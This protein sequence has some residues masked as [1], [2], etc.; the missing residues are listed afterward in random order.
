[1]QTALQKHTLNQG[2]ALLLLLLKPCKQ[3]HLQSITARGDHTGPP[4][5]APGWACLGTAPAL[6]NLPGA[7]RVTRHCGTGLYC[8][9]TGN[10]HLMDPIA[11]SL[12]LG[13]P[14][15]QSR[16]PVEVQP[17]HLAPCTRSETLGSPDKSRQLFPCGR[18][19][20]EGTGQPGCAGS[21]KHVSA[22]LC[23][24]RGVLT[25]PGQACP[26]VVASTR[27]GLLQL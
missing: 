7:C 14:L 23:R 26:W 1:M 6:R 12:P 27:L 21:P 18:E 9:R 8:A 13:S 19:G 11:R 15:G 4:R 17:R 2:C 16:H 22:S 5:G 3:K 20:R 10:Q 24:S 25:N